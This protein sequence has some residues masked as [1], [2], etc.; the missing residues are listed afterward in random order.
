ME[1]NIIRKDLVAPG[2]V[3]GV[4]EEFM[5]GENIYERDGYLISSIVGS[6]IIDMKSRI[7][8]VKPS[9]EIKRI[10]QGSFVYAIVTSTRGE[11]AMS[12]ILGFSLVNPIRNNLTG[13]LHVSQIPSEIKTR[14][15]ED[16]IRVGDVIYA[17]IIS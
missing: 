3:I 11:I 10:T 17:K 16:L 12:R 4:I 5:P 1:E 15:I 2:S 8:Y 7:A 6:L 14:F 9:K 13:I